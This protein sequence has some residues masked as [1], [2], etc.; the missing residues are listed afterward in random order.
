MQLLFIK[1]RLVFLTLKKRVLTLLGLLILGMLG[2]QGQEKEERFQGVWAIKSDTSEPIIILLKPDNEAAYFKATNADRTIYKGTWSENGSTATATWLDGSTHNFR[3]GAFN[4]VAT[5]TSVLGKQS[6]TLAT[7]KL[8][9]EILGQWAKKP[10]RASNKEVTD[11]DRNTFFGIWQQAGENPADSIYLI[12]SKDRSAATLNPNSSHNSL[13]GSW[14]K[15]GSELHLTWENGDYSILRETERGYA[16]KAIPAGQNIEKAAR[17]FKTIAR[18]TEERAP[19]AWLKSCQVHQEQT[20]AGYI[21][22]SRKAARNFYRGEW[23][24]QH[25]AS[26]FERITIRRYGSLD[27]S[28]DPNLHGDWLLSGQD[29]MLR[30]DDGLRKILS[31]VGRGFVLYIYQPGRALDGVPTRILAATPEAN[32]KLETLLLGRRA[33]AQTLLEKAQKAG[34]NLAE[35]GLNR[36]FSRIWPFTNST[37]KL[38][39]SA[40]LTNDLQNGANTAEGYSNDP[41]WWPLWSDTKT[42]AES[43]KAKSPTKLDANEKS[44]EPAGKTV[45]ETETIHKSNNNW[46]W[47]F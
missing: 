43:N 24:I 42:D 9:A 28:R 35:Q 12:V 45:T 13:H 8:S 40:L 37:S 29:A 47:P 34:I 22:E 26:A 36:G 2:L 46:F 17:N 11:K 15:Q 3:Q 4:L 23:L 14:A 39:S 21:F 44:A 5:F 27:T 41:W 7:Q 30:W 32:K 19:K 6:E 31:P 1:P 33:F 16:Y 25:E 10:E 20:P 38:N 18:I